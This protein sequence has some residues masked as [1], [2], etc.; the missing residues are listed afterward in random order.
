LYLLPPFSLLLP[1]YLG[2][3]EVGVASV[4]GVSGPSLHPS[5]KR[6]VKYFNFLFGDDN[7]QRDGYLKSIAK[8]N[9]GCM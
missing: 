9:E 7:Y 4:S 6:I 8:E 2:D 3:D 1:E 5:C